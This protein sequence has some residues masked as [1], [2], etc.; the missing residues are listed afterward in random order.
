MDNMVVLL[1]NEEGDN[2]KKE[3][4]EKQFDTAE[5]LPMKATA[6]CPR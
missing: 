3:M 1:K 6:R 5:D 4:Y 2:D